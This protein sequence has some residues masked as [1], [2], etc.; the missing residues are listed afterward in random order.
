MIDMFNQPF[1]LTT[2]SPWPIITSFNIFNL[3]SSSIY[4]F[5]Y[6][7]INCILFML[8]NIILSSY[9]WWRDTIRESL[10]QGTYTKSIYSNLKFGMI[11]FITSE[12]MFFF[13]FF[14]AYFHM[15]L[16]PSMELGM[17]WP[18]MNIITFNPFNIPL[19]N[20]IILIASSMSLTWTHHSTLNQMNFPMIISMMTTLIL[21]ITFT[22]F[23]MYEYTHANFSINDSIYGSMFFLLTGFHGL[24]VL[25][26]TIFLMT[27]FIRMLKNHFSKINHFS[28][29]ASIWYWHFVDVVWLFLFITLYWLIN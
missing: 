16:S 1:H 24:H 15:F 6:N 14:W 4:L 12:V 9:Q 20:T 2:M 23:Q 28:M 27:N 22:I 18:P 10:H 29:E 8:M 25:I 7:N 17:N 11:L 5:N 19:L 21:G 26:G 3:L 13:S